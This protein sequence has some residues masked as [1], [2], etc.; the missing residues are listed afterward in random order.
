MQFRIESFFNPHL[1][2]GADRIDAVITVTATSTGDPVTRRGSRNRAIAFVI[3]CSGSMKDHGRLDA[4]RHAARVCLNL[5]DETTW[6]SVIAFSYDAQILM[7]LS[8]ATPQNK[9]RAHMEIQKLFGDG[10]TVF[11]TALLAAREQ[12]L[13]LPEGIRYAL[14]LTDGENDPQDH[15]DL[16]RAVEDCKG[17]F[18]CDGRGVGSDWKKA[19]LT[20]IAN[21][22]LG[23]AD[24]IPGGEM[25]EPAFREAIG[26]ALA[27]G[28]ADVRLR[29]WSPRTAT[30]T[31]IKQVSP[32]IVD[33][34][35]LAVRKDDKTIEVPVG[36]WAEETRDYHVTLSFAP[37][38]VGEEML[39]CRPS[40]VYENAGQEIVVA[41]PPVIATWTSDVTLATRISP[42]VAHY[43]GQQEL[44]DSIKEG[45]AARERGDLDQATKLLGN[46]AKIAAKSG[47]EEVTRRLKHV[48]DI[49]DAPQ[50]TVRLR[51]AVSKADELVL[52]MGGTRTV[53]RKIS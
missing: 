44:A 30:T 52:D 28:V 13:K 6:F 17:L 53:R 8:Q 4:A 19:D 47:N 11:S 48:V 38:D 9:E 35:S 1:S 12:L 51:S 41:A 40:V 33:L 10:G 45:L 50:G 46:A 20:L 42:Q 29:L 14:F 31:M 24:I 18:Q 32:E 43:T 3:D 15:K 26:A 25:M 5:L 16:G 39:V 23:N 7:P 36:S 22:L 34:R 21:T 27:K 2:A 37:G 49:V